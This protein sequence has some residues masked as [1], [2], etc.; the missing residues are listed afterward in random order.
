MSLVTMFFIGAK[1][2]PGI[3]KVMEKC[4]EVIQVCAKLQATLG[5]SVLPAPSFD[6]A[7]GRGQASAIV[8]WDGTNLKERLEDEMGDALAAFDFVIHHGEL[9]SARIAARRREKRALFEKWQVEQGGYGLPPVTGTVG[10]DAS[11][12]P[13]VPLW[14]QASSHTAIPWVGEV[15]AASKWNPPLAPGL[16]SPALMPGQ[17]LVAVHWKMKCEHRDD[18]TGADWVDPSG[19][20]D[21]CFQTGIDAL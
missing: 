7:D 19:E 13:I 14:N 9:N 12:H 1:K 4:A 15:T 11:P 20:C 8:H 6:G 3:T 17:R 16:E 18:M 2:W 5:E 21:V 10:V